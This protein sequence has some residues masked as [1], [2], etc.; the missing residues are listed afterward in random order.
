M[1]I[2][3]QAPSF[4]KLKAVL[5]EWMALIELCDD[6]LERIELYGIAHYID[7]EQAEKK[8]RSNW[9]MQV[10]KDEETVIDKTLSSTKGF[11]G[12]VLVNVSR[13]LSGYLS[14]FGLVGIL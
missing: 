11:F 7:I 12:N 8:L 1:D 14:W 13:Q 5:A 9:G 4:T 6:L 2:L 3:N 10:Q